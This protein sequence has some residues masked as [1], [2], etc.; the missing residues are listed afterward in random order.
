MLKIIQDRWKSAMDSIN[1]IIKELTIIFEKLQNHPFI[2]IILL[3]L[4][5]LYI[6]CVWI[7]KWHHG[8]YTIFGVEFSFYWLEY[9][10][11]FFACLHLFFIWR[12]DLLKLLVV[13]SFIVVFSLD[14]FNRIYIFYEPMYKLSFVAVMIPLT[15]TLHVF[16][17]MIGHN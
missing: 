15:T 16:G 14:L 8:K 13:I 7:E 6:P 17:H 2:N 9:Y 5:G 1:G 11:F 10:E 3:L 4:I 12:R